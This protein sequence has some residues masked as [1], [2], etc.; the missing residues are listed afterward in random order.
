ML[1]RA[2][3]RPAFS[4]IIWPKRPCVGWP[5]TPRRFS[6]SSRVFLQERK[7]RYAF[8]F[9]RFIPQYCSHRYFRR[10]TLRRCRGVSHAEPKFPS[11][12]AARL[13]TRSDIAVKHPLVK[14]PRGPS[15]RNAV[16]RRVYF[17]S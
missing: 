3:E 12:S 4:D 6:P 8:F 17:C 7:V 5:N 1:K 15:P 2:L 10:T 11:T 16:D 13:E 14:R 9:E